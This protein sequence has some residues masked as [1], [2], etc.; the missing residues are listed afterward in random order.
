MGE[1]ADMRNMSLLW[2]SFPSMIFTLIG[3]CCAAIN[4]SPLKFLFHSSAVEPD[5]KNLSHSIQLIAACLPYNIPALRLRSFVFSVHT[6][7]YLDFS[8]DSFLQLYWFIF[9]RSKCHR[10]MRSSIQS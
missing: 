3:M 4:L 8:P 9:L 6:C 5:L 1:I 2:T 10:R 7:I